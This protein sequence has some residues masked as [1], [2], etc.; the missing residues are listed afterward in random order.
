MNYMKKWVIFL[1]V[2]SGFSWIW[3]WEREHSSFPYDD[4]Q[5]GLQDHL[6]IRFSHV[7]AEHTPKGLA[8]QIFASLVH[9]KSNGAIKVEVYPNAMLYSDE[10]EIKALQKGDIEMI[11]PAFSKLTSLSPSWQV[12]DLPFIF[13][14]EK[15]ANEALRGQLGESLFNELKPLGIHGLAFWANGFKQMTNSV[16]PLKN[17]SDFQSLR[18][19]TMPSPVIQRQFELLGATT[20]AIPFNETYRFLY[21]GMLDGQEN[22]ISNIYTKKFY[23][24]QPFITISNHAYLGYAVLM[25]EAF[26]SRLTKEQQDIITEALAEATEWMEKQAEQMNKQQLDILKQD[27]TLYI[28]TLTES[29]KEEWK[30]KLQPLYEEFLNEIEE[31]ML[32]YLPWFETKQLIKDM[33]HY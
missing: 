7:V 24:V 17:P 18:F 6:V 33:K 16:R 5:E 2:L 11:A 9:E 31:P 21:H 12:L 19:R 25:N 29:E 10:E 1:I 30:E 23:E 27:K 32:Q 22:T 20:K 8:A 13:K 3:L 4:E 15:E 14:H 28:H 26:W